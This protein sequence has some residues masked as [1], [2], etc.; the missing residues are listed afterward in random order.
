MMPYSSLPQAAK[1]FFEVVAIRYS[2]EMLKQELKICE[3]AEK[4]YQERVER[5]QAKSKSS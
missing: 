2:I 3:N 1:D 5:C 4:K